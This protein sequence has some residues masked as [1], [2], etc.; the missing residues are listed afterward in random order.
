MTSKTQSSSSRQRAL[1]IGKELFDGRRLDNVENVKAH[2]RPIQGVGKS[3]SRPDDVKYA[4]VRRTRRLA[5]PRIGFDETQEAA[6]RAE[7]KRLGCSGSGG[8]AM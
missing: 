1:V 6:V 8:N 3:A 5:R 2:G 7:S 4:Q